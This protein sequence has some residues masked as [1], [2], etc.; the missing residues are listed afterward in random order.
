MYKGEP[1]TGIGRALAEV[2][3][4]FPNEGAP[5]GESCMTLLFL[6]HSKEE[7]DVR[8]IGSRPWGDDVDPVVLKKLIQI[9]YSVFKG[10][11]E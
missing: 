5:N 8:S 7:P 10:T 9:A 2:I 3:Q 4:W 11:S 6:E 1:L